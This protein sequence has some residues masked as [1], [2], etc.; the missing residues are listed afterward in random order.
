MDTNTLDQAFSK[1]TEGSSGLNSVE[2]NFRDWLVN[3]N[4]IERLR[5]NPYAVASAS[6]APVADIVALA[7]RGVATG[8]FDLHW[9]VHC[10][11][12]NMI[13][14]EC[15]NFFE[16]T[17]SSDCKMCDVDFDVDT[18]TRVE[19]TFSLNRSIEDVDA[20]AFCLPPPVLCSKVNI[21]VGPGATISGTDTIDEP[22]TYRFFCP[23]TLAKGILEISGERTDQ[24]QAF[25]VQQLPTLNYAETFFAARPRPCPV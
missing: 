9:L 16:L 15:G 21:A 11:H 25:S 3:S 23:I 5:I 7:L 2:Q 18:L 8:L 20:T 12:C 14:K 22:G 6:D 13:T 1:L 17:H 24:V 19:V 10:P 4:E